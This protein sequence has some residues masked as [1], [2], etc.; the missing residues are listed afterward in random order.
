MMAPEARQAARQ[1][2]RMLNGT[3]ST[4]EAQILAMDHS[5]AVTPPGR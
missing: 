2:L 3:V 5:I 4:D 1:H